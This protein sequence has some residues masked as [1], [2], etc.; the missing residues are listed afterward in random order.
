MAE[1]VLE[2]NPNDFSAE[3]DVSVNAM[4]GNANSQA[5]MALY[6]HQPV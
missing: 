4:A 2:S 5:A 1:A 6:D 3:N